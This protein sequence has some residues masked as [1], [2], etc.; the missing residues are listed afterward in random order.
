M[1]EV[2]VVIPTYNAARFLPQAIGSVLGQTYRDLEVVVVDN[3]ST[4]ETPELMA[5][6]GAPVRY[7]RQDNRG[8]AGSRNR[9]L[10]ESRG[11]WVAF[12]DADD[13]WLPEKLARQ[14]EALRG[15]PSHRACYT[16]FT[17]TD[18]DLSPLSTQRSHRQG[19]A[20]EDLLTLGN[21]IGTP[22]TVLFERRLH[23]EVGG[24]DPALSYG[25][26]WDLW[27]RLARRTEFLYVDEPLVQYRQHG[28]NMSRDVALLE[29]D[30]V[31]LL[32]KAYAMPDLPDP[33][34]GRRRPALARNY[35]VLAG[36]H[37]RAGSY[38][39]AVRCALRALA[40]DVRQAGRLLGFPA[41]AAARWGRGGTPTA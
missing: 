7:F 22:S 2:S 34:R 27:I 23:E 24:F 8:P 12:L 37:F 33:L 32:E 21:V 11:R 35:M 13:A 31:R 1:P 15:S 41:R 3:D 18:Q 29:S 39:P 36:S 25:A 17:F 30:S 14:M 20:L 40:L 4:D 16:A 28:G 10:A 9:G 5:G 19:T 26:D 6:Y 38:G